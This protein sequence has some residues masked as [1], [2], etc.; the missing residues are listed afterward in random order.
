[1]KVRAK[2]R[3]AYINQSKHIIV[4]LLLLIQLV[5]G[6]LGIH[7]GFNLFMDN[8][9]KKDMAN[10]ILTQDTYRIEG[11]YSPVRDENNLNKFEERSLATIKL[12]Q[13]RE[14]N[15]LC[16]NE[17]GILAEYFNGAMNIGRYGRIESIKGK[18][19]YDA[20]VLIVN[21]L[22]MEYYDVKVDKGRM[23][24]D[25]ELELKFD[26]PSNVKVL[27]GYEYSKFFDIGDK[28]INFDDTLKELEIVGFLP[29]DMTISN[30][31]VGN[32]IS[33]NNYIIA[34]YN[35]HK[36]AEILLERSIINASYLIYDKEMDKNEIKGINDDLI[37]SFNSIHGGN[38]G[39]RNI[40]H[41]LEYDNSIR[42]PR[43][44]FTMKM[45]GI[46][47]VF[48]FSAI[49][50]SSIL[51]ID[52]RKKE[53]AVHILSGATLR[54]LCEIVFIE[55]YSLFILSM[56]ISSTIISIVTKNMK[57]ERLVIINIIF[58]ILAIIISIIPIIIKKPQVNNVLKGE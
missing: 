57:I 10:K 38:I 21:K 42:E 9:E 36:N 41:L 39:L 43:V 45:I 12:F 40:N 53:F 28:I 31:S 50:I 49:I 58:M 47:L 3:Y 22:F 7:Y 37:Q 17:Y 29:K 2:I 27:A 23:L 18:T 11:L 48:I 16:Q 32:E 14:E 55:I 33:L 4:N 19:Y 44:I 34:G 52:K 13:S 25:E 35:F 54:D 46:I 24:T 8:K 6:F 51:L 20:P 30:F 1:M 56:V 15:F 5:V 26:K